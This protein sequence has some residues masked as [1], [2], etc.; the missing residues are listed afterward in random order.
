MKEQITGRQGLC[1]MAMFIVGSSLIVGPRN[2]AGK[3]SWLAILIGMVYAIPVL[4][5]YARLKKLQP[6]MD[7]Y[8][9]FQWIFG[10]VAGKVFVALYTWYAFF[11]GGLVTRNFSEFISIEAFPETPRFVVVLFIGLMSI[12]AVK[13]GMETLGRWST[14]FLVLMV[15]VIGLIT[16]FGIPLYNTDNLKP[17]ADKG[18]MPLLDG[19]Y[20]IFAYPFAE[21][22]IFSLAFCTFKPK[23]SIYKVYY[24]AL[25]IAAAL[26]ATGSLRDVLI[27]GEPL[28]D[29]LYHPSYRSASVIYL[30]QSFYRFE[31][32]IGLAFLLC[33]F[34]K[35]LVLMLATT[36]GMAKLFN[37]Q[38]HKKI[39]AP[40]G[41][42]MMLL[43]I[44][45][46][47]SMMD[48]VEWYTLFRYYTIPFQVIIPPAVWVIAEIKTRRDR[49]KKPA[50]TP[51]TITPD[52]SGP[53]Y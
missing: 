29:K 2:E 3:D 43:S 33:G 44:I 21:T 36:K 20:S 31:I 35:I 38:D 24:G 14:I 52:K 30:G 5:I 17:V 16:L 41:L 6:E 32:V 34:V 47:S 19:G 25:G 53:A 48:N 12:Y 1:L 18:L 39:A 15:I 45:I 37:I 40:V 23:S 49:R 27:L 26:L 13:C 22:I 9:L 11:L 28:Y 42:L 8:D 7:L 51:E 46:Y 4:F 50:P 10:K